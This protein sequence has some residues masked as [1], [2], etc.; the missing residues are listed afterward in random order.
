MVVQARAGEMGEHR[1]ACCNSTHILPP[2]LSMNI[3]LCRLKTSRGK[4]RLQYGPLRPFVCSTSLR[5]DATWLGK[6]VTPMSGSYSRTRTF[7]N[8]PPCH[9]NK[10]F[11]EKRNHCRLLP[12]IGNPDQS[13]TSRTAA[14][15]KDTLR[16]LLHDGLSE[17]CTCCSPISTFD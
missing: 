11:I 10:Q 1:V 13:Q 6:H 15:C 14:L 4:S 16:A 17:S 8:L 2:W 7:P 9:I 3:L 12:A 5:H